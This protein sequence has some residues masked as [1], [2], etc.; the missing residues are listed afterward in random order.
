MSAQTA[1]PV[2]ADGGGTSAARRYRTII[3]VA[4]VTVAVALLI[5]WETASRTELVDP[6]FVSSP[7]GVVARFLAWVE[8]G[9]FFTDL[10]TTMFVVATGWVLAGLIGNL[11]GFAIGLSSRVHRFAAPFVDAFNATPRI[12][13]VP[14]FILWL[15]IGYASHLALI[16]SVNVVIG[17]IAASSAA[18]SVDE[19]LVTLAR[20]LGASRASAVAKVILPWSIPGVFAGLRI[21]LAYAFAGAAVAEMLGS[22]QG[23][24]N[25][26]ARSSNV[27]DVA[28]VLSAVLVLVLLAALS[29]AALRL[30]ED[31]L[32]RWRP[33][34]NQGM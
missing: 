12:A 5:A 31:H 29:N 13:L 20:T 10:R 6:F 16:L 30:L 19:D 32:L 24:G 26:I 14:L 1:S 3:L 11:I 23:I 25:F 15:G 34:L 27:L 4:R 8:S 28:G 17:I 22:R 18:Q 7:T 2:G 33:R 21:G 9:R